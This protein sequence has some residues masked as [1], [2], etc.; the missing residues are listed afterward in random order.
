MVHF[1]PRLEKEGM[2]KELS[3][4]FSYEHRNSK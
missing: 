3:G 2:R 4:I 1:G